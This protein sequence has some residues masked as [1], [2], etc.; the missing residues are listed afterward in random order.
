MCSFRTPRSHD[1]MKTAVHAR[2]Q[3][4]SLGLVIVNLQRT[5]YDEGT[6]LRIF[7]KIDDVMEMLA[8]RL[9]LTPQSMDLEYLPQLVPGAYI[10][11]DVVRVPFDA[12]GRPTSRGERH[13]LDLRNGRRVLVTGGTYEGD[14][15]TVME[16]RDG[17]YRIRFEGSV[18]PTFNVKRRPFSL[19]LGS[20]WLQEAT[21][22]FGIMPGGHIPVVNVAV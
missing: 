8:A 14:V 22:G 10:E 4:R 5:A 13:E 20:W 18:H 6:S 19:W 7:A 11:E 1:R 21:C 2:S 16:K 17:H 3:R 12:L 9:Q 15:G